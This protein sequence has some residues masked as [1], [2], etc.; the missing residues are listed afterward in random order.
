MLH[1]KYFKQIWTV[2]AGQI[3]QY[4]GIAQ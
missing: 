4:L 1:I 3:F 2:F